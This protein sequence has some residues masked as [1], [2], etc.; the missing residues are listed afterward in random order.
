MYIPWVVQWKPISVSPKFDHLV[1]TPFLCNGHCF[2]QKQIVRQCNRRQPP[3][4][5]SSLLPAVCRDYFE[6]LHF[7][8]MQFL[9][10]TSLRLD[11]P[12]LRKQKFHRTL[13]N[14]DP[15]VIARSWNLSPNKPLLQYVTFHQNFFCMFAMEIGFSDLVVKR[16]W[17]LNNCCFAFLTHHSN[18]RKLL[19]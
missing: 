16:T 19:V 2:C 7:R 18:V 17:V 10:R 1:Y 6:C 14:R 13:N 8:C 5:T 15:Q 3:S 9:Q 4:S 12:K 11:A